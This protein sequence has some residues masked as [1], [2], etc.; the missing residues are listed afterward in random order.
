MQQFI[1]ELLDLRKVKEREAIIIGNIIPYWHAIPAYDCALVRLAKLEL[2]FH[3]YCWYIALQVLQQ[4]LLTINWSHRKQKKIIGS[5]CLTMTV[6][7][8][9]GEIE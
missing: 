8:F 6:N 5:H 4:M 1:Y 7:S 3:E 2:F 9:F